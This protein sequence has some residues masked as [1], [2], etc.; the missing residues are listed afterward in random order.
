MRRLPKTSRPN[1]SNVPGIDL[2]RLIDYRDVV[3]LLPPEIVYSGAVDGVLPVGGLI[4]KPDAVWI[5]MFFGPGSASYSAIIA[6]SVHGPSVKHSLTLPI[7]IDSPVQGTTM[8]MLSKGR[9][10][11]MVQDG[12]ELVRLVGLP[13][14]PL[15]LKQSTLTTTGRNIWMVELATET[16]YPAYYL[17]GWTEDEL[18]GNPA[19]YSFD[20]SLDFNA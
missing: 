18:Y 19:D 7:P 20:F 1:A 11:A 2:V 16:L 6:Q 3:G 4:P 13:S 14:Q 15:K 8:K 10:L 5:D 9:F 17:T 12:N